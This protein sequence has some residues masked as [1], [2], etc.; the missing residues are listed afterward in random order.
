MYLGSLTVSA[1]GNV[2][3]VQGQDIQCYNHT[4]QKPFSC[5]PNVAIGML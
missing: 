5:S 3:L 2:R 4:V 1:S